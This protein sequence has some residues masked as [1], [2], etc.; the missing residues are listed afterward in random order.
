MEATVIRSEAP[1]YCNQ[2]GR[3]SRKPMQLADYAV[4]NEES[5][6]R[7]PTGPFTYQRQQTKPPGHGKA[8]HFL[9]VSRSSAERDLT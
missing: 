6:S 3:G 9:I 4:S 8:P 2:G 1:R 5:Q 7:N